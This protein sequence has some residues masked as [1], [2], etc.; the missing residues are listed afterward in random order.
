MFVINNWREK[1]CFFSGKSAPQRVKHRKLKMNENAHIKEVLKLVLPV[2]LPNWIFG[3]GVIEYPL[4][5]PHP[6]LSLFYLLFIITTYC[7]IC[8][9][10]HNEIIEFATTFR[11]AVP[12]KITLYSNIIIFITIIIGG[13]YRSE[14]KYICIYLK[15]YKIFQKKW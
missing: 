15:F 8:M 4:G 12:S 2:Y 13:W 5:T 6:I 1:T 11:T 14:V 7:I 3:I 9:L 10:S